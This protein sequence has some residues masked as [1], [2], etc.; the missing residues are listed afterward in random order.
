MKQKLKLNSVIGPTCRVSSPGSST[1][2]GAL[3]LLLERFKLLLLL[4]SAL[5][6]L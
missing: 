5:L 6:G 1:A 4:F 2:E 3:G